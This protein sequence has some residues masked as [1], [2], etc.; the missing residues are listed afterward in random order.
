MAQL[1]GFNLLI[2]L[3]LFPSLMPVSPSLMRVSPSLMMV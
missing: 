2:P 1:P 3:R